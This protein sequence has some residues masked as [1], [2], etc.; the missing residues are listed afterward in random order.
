[1]TVKIF[2]QKEVS[3]GVD[4]RQINALKTSGAEKISDTAEVPELMKEPGTAEREKKSA[5]MN[6]PQV[7]VDISAGLYRRKVY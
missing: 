1:M 5:S 6:E 2:F 7:S 4:D 3:E